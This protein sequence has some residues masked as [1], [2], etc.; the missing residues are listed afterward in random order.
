MVFSGSPHVYTG[1][2]LNCGVVTDRNGTV[3]LDATDGRQYSDDVML[4]M[5]TLHLLGDRDGYI[6]APAVSQYS[7]QMVGFDLVNGIY[8]TSG[9]GGTAVLTISAE[10]QKAALEALDGRKGVVG[11]YNYKNR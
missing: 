7:S 5:A 10:A 3:L 6:N 8:S 2:N 9:T 1:N 4:R 11:V